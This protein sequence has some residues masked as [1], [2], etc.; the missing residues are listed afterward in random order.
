M[1]KLTIRQKAYQNF[2]GRG[3]IPGVRAHAA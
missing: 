1:K 2:R 3:L